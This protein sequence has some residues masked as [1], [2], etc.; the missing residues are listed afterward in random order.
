MSA[1]AKNPGL[2]D[3]CYH[4][5]HAAV[6]ALNMSFEDSS[7]SDIANEI[8]KLRERINE[9]EGKLNSE[10]DYQMFTIRCKDIQKISLHR[11]AM[12]SMGFQC[13]EIEVSRG[14][15]EDSLEKGKFFFGCKIPKKKLT[16]E[17]LNYLCTW[18]RIVGEG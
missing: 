10:V 1:A 6:N 17:M 15:K 13:N 3:Q 12:F 18:D 8:G 2:A 7:P 5:A 14:W 11:D 4:M 16:S 9:L